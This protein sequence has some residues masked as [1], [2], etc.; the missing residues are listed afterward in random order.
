MRLA[1]ASKGAPT[2]VQL[3]NGN[4]GE[5]VGFVKGHRRAVNACTWSPDGRLF[6]T[7]GSDGRVLVRG[8]RGGLKAD[9]HLFNNQSESVDWSP[10]GKH[11]AVS[12]RDG[13]VLVMDPLSGKVS[14]SWPPG[15][16]VLRAAWHPDSK[17]LAVAREDAR[18]YIAEPHDAEVTMLVHRSGVSDLAWSPDG[19]RLATASQD[20]SV[21]EW[22]SEGT[23]RHMFM[24]PARESASSVSYS[25]DGSR[26]AAASWDGAVRVWRNE[27]LEAE[28]REGHGPP[29]AVEWRPGKE[30]ELL[31][32]RS[33][34]PL[35]LLEL[36]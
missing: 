3:L 6:A 36:R 8:P 10:D 19:E 30:L 35:R 21:R 1:T 24:R 13:S 7:A 34:G 20:G 14:Y 12:A 9:H 17:R 28:D 5:E 15:P 26:L 31:V 25:P 23:M 2:I 32:G 4:T 33:K 29:V 27:D 18:V 16:T 22:S 11:L